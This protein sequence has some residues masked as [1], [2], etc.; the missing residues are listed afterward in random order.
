MKGFSLG[1]IEVKNGVLCAPICGATKVPYRQ[2][3]QRYGADL[4]YTEMIT[5][6][7]L[8]RSTERSFE[9]ARIGPDEQRVGAQI[10]GSDAELLAEASRML[11]ARGFATIDLN[12]GCPV[13]KVVGQG[14]GA[15][16]MKDPAR[17]EAL[18]RAMSDAVSVPVTIKIRSG[19]SKGSVNAIDIARAAEQGGAGWVSIHGRPRSERHSGTVDFETMAEVK[20]AVSIPVIGN[21]GIFSPEDAVE[22]V[23]K[24]GC[25][26]VMIGRGGFGRPWFF[27]DCARALRGEAQRPRPDARELEVIL[28]E[29]LEGLLDLLGETMGV[30]SFRK[31]LS[32]YMRTGQP[33]ATYFRDL[34]FR[35]KSRAE[36]LEI[37][38]AWTEHSERAKAYMGSAHR[39]M[40]RPA[41]LARFDEGPQPEWLQRDRRRQER[42]DGAGRCSLEACES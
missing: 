31:V 3:A 24:T 25:D 33:W 37:I 11:E 21:G 16:L 29:H 28:L 1:E 13:K 9:L 2:L 32:W 30:R 27:E 5:S 40:P 18:V 35:C 12:A 4:C 8:V 42:E 23:E 26:A 15:A 39:S 17:L 6:A 22:M 38:A 7:A 41:I 10:C 14:S 36:M 20:G 19:W 34:A